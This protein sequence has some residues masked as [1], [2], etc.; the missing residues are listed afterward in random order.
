MVPVEDGYGE[1]VARLCL[2]CDEQLDPPPS[3]ESDEQPVRPTTAGTKGKPK[4]GSRRGARLRGPVPVGDRAPKP[5]ATVK[6]GRRSRLKPAFFTG[7]AAAVGYGFGLVQLLGV[8]LPVAEQ[9]AVGMVSLLLAVVGG[10]GAWRLFGRPEI[11]RIFPVPILA[12]ILATLGAAELCRRM[13]PAPVDWLN[14]HGQQWGLG[15]SAVS[16]LLTAG[17][18]CVGLWWLIDSRVRH[19]SLLFRWLARIPLASALLATALYAPGTTR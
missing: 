14:D 1:V 11:G 8:Y 13:A 6:R 2:V 16:L 10:W 17:G 7:S 18:M 3:A 15:A 12:R 5:K 4:A 9:A 19:K